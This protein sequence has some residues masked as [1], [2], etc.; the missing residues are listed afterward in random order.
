MQTT[1]EKVL[2]TSFILLFLIASCGG[3]DTGTNPQPNNDSYDPPSVSASAITGNLNNTRDLH[4]ATLLKDGRV[5]VTGG[6]DGIQKLASCELYNPES[7]TWSL[8]GEMS[9][10]RCFHTATLLDDGRVFVTGGAGNDENSIIWFELFDP[11]SETWSEINYDYGPDEDTTRMS[12]SR[13]CHSATLLKDGK[14]LVTGGF[15]SYL[16]NENNLPGDYQRTYELYDP[17]TNI[18]TI[19]DKDRPY[20]RSRRYCHSS[21]LLPDGTVL[22]TGGFNYEDD[23]HPNCEIYYPEPDTCLSVTPMSI[24]RMWHDAFLLSSGKVFI[25]T[26]K[27]GMTTYTRDCRVYDL[28]ADSWAATGQNR[29]I[30]GQSET[31]Q[32]IDGRILTAGNYYSKTTEIYDPDTGTWNFSADMFEYRKLFTMTTFDNGVVLIAGGLTKVSGHD[33]FLNSCELY[34]P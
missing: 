8:V 13:M 33:T 27:D 16:T 2:P 28:A 31:T 22:I 19:P 20:M 21:T 17:E 7:G 30:R 32:L 11:L 6:F 23:Y 18:C 10:A 29:E 12:K 9:E 1:R 14:V 15:N 24:G 26:G 25:T 4:T 5:L 34:V 3:D